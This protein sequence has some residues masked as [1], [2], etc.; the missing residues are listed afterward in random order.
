MDSSPDFDR[1]RRA[2]DALAGL[3]GAFM[4][5]VMW[6]A[7]RDFKVYMD[8]ADFHV[9]QQVRQLQIP[10]DAC[11]VA[12][13]VEGSAEAWQLAGGSAALARG[14]WEEAGLGKAPEVELW[15]RDIA[16]GHRYF[17]KMLAWDQE[18]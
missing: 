6:I 3:P 7:Y 8:A 2:M 13:A 16:G 11:A 1:I 5:T 14:A 4:L 18:A 9:G 15:T 12:V 10:E 17:V